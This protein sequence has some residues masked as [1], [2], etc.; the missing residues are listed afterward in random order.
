MVKIDGKKVRRIRES[1]GLTQLYLA[2]AV[3]VTTDTISRWENRRYPT[4]KRENGIRLAE[5]LEVDLEEILEND[6]SQVISAETGEE[7]KLNS[8][9]NS[10]RWKPLVYLVV[11]IAL[12]LV[13]VILYN[14]L[15]GSEKNGKLVSA[16]RMLPGRAAAGQT[17][18]VV[19][20]LYGSEGSEQSVI[21]KESLPAG[22]VVQQANPP[23]T[24][25][26]Q[27]GLELKWLKKIDGRVRFTYLVRFRSTVEKIVEFSGTVAAAGG[28]ITNIDGDFQLIVDRSHW[29]DRDGDGII[30]DTEILHVYDE[31]SEIEGLDIERIERMWAGSG[32]RWNQKKE[33][34]EILE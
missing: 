25:L 12:V 7:V 28:K 17:F 4:I 3:E 6:E 24:A 15:Q 23:V 27:K 8:F 26:N 22:T 1:K 33:L 19:I 34:F 18:P 2:T 29:A 14:L 31:F 9:L 30:S 21:L 20:E 16:V 10:N 11:G 32:Y 5:A 13:V